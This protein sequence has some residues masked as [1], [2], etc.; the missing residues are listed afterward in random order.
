MTMSI[1][2]FNCPHCVDSYAFDFKK[3]KFVTLHS[4]VRVRCPGCQNV[5]EV[6]TNAYS[7]IHNA[8]AEKY[9]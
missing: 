2:F 3:L 1:A 7:V 9:Q 4:R 5:I 8:D 6:V